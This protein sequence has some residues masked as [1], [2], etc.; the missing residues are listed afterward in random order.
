MYDQTGSKNVKVKEEVVRKEDADGRSAGRK[1]GKEI[2]GYDFGF[3]FISPHF[4][5]IKGLVEEFDI[6]SEVNSYVGATTC[7]EIS[8]E[9]STNDAAVFLGVKSDEINF[10]VGGSDSGY[11]DPR[12]AGKEAI[13]QAQSESFPQ[14]GKNNLV[15]VLTPGPTLNE[16]NKDTDVLKGILSEA[17]DV[18]VVGGSA[19]DDYALK[20]TYQVMNGDVGDSKVV[21]ATIATD[22][23]IETGKEHGFADR[24]VTGL[25]TE[26]D[27]HTLKKIGDKPAA[28][29]Y[30]DAIDVEEKE[31]SQPLDVSISKQLKMLPRIV[32]SKLKGKNPIV[33]KKVFEYSLDHA[34]A[35]EVGDDLRILTPYDVTEDGGLLLNTKISENKAVYVVQGERDEIIS[36]AENIFE[37]DSA[38]ESFA[39][40]N[41]CSARNMM[42]DDEELE[43]EVR[44]IEESINGPV[45]GFYGMGEI[46]GKNKELCTVQNSTVSGFMVSEN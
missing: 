29:F 4:K 42:L 32:Y 17:G 5:D 15:Y 6:H 46:G 43:E 31:L 35:D 20:N 23:E 13:E 8:S 26:T 27:G 30:A 19:G 40:I 18:S 21:V 36:A 10:S 37:E 34:F 24:K 25:V 38:E 11:S 16:E 41:D 33:P 7:G 22:K 3:L 9:G 12:E 1:L 45:V 28:E 39:V 2:E 44:R 14:E